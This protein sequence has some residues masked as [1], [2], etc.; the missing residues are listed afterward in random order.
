MTGRVLRSRSP[1]DTA[2][3]AAALADVVRG[4]DLLVLT[5]DLGAGKT[6]FTKALAAGLGVT[7]PVTS[8]TFTL[9]NRYQGALTVHHLD[10]YRLD[11][12]T[13]V[14]DLGLDELIGPDSLTVVEWGD[15]IALALPGDRLDVD[16]TL[17]DP[18]EGLDDD[19][20]VITLT[21][22]GPSW[23][24]RL[25]RLVDDPALRPLGVPC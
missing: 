5:G 20:R 15:T 9:A 13:D 24:P 12:P 10:A 6:V 1:A 7:A 19:H 4:G 25:D 23:R 3:L 8:P 22:T 16:L 21:A 2:A 17:H 18:D 11:G 14:R